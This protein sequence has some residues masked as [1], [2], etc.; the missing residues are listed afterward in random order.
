MN[1]RAR[2]R[3]YLTL[4]A[5][6]TFL[7]EDVYRVLRRPVVPRPGYIYAV[8]IL[9]PMGIR[10]RVDFLRTTGGLTYDSPEQFVEGIRWRLGSLTAAEEMRLL[11]YF[12]RLPRAADGTARYRH[13]FEWAMLSWEKGPR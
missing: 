5:G 8:N 10:A 9:Y 13:D 1:S 12:R 7:S 11:A 3:C 6:T 4:H 2:L